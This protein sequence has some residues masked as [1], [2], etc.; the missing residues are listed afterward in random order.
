MMK[1]KFDVYKNHILKIIWSND[2]ENYI[3]LR[4]LYAFNFFNIDCFFGFVLIWMFVT[5]SS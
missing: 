3:I 4:K 2:F 5:E 1:K